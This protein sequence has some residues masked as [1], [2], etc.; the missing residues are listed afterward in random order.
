M[1]FLIVPAVILALVIYIFALRWL[2]KEK[3]E[4]HHDNSQRKV[5]RYSTQELMDM[6]RDW[7]LKQKMVFS[8]KFGFL[9]TKK[10]AFLFPSNLI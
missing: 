3:S 4:E 5:F 10:P 1:E 9:K 2:G 6:A 7:I 8:K